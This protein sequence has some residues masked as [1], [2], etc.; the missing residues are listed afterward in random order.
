MNWLKIAFLAIIYDDYRRVDGRTVQ[1]FVV[2]SSLLFLH[3]GVGGLYHL[4]TKPDCMVT[5]S[6]VLYYTLG[7]VLNVYHGESE[8]KSGENTVNT[9]KITTCIFLSAPSLKRID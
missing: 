2:Y 5:A 3:N 6:I 1:S 9:I 4:K 7:C 8:T